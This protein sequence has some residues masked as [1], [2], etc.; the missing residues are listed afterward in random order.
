MIK[1]VI[2]AD[3]KFGIGKNGSLPWPKNKED[4][5]WFKEQTMHNIVIMGRRTWEDPLMP[6]PL[7]MRYN[8]VVS[9]YPI[10]MFNQTPHVV[11]HPNNIRNYC[12]YLK[13]GIIIGGAVLLN[14]VIPWIDEIHL[15]RISGDWN[16]DRFIDIPNSIFTLSET[17][18]Y[19]DRG[20][21][22]EKYKRH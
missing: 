8:V 9:R 14:N 11:V 19:H 6:K 20:L 5:K 18:Q 13:N 2:A 17:I 7:P 10:E 4:M 16:C 1:A 15:S 12:S 21:K 3:D 22:I